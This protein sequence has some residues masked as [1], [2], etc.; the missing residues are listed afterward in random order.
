M[1]RGAVHH[2]AV[3]RRRDR[4]VALEPPRREPEQVPA[5]SQ[6]GRSYNRPSSSGQPPIGPLRRSRRWW[7]LR[8]RRSPARRRTVRP[9]RLTWTSDVKIARAAVPRAAGARAART[10]TVTSSH[11]DLDY[12]GFGWAR[13]ER[14]W[15]LD[16][17]RRRGSR[18]TTRSCSRSTPPTTREA[19]ADDIELEFE[20]PRP[21]SG[22][23]AGCRRSSSA[24]CRGCRRRRRSCSRCATRTARRRVPAA[25]ATALVHVALG[26]VDALARP[27]TTAASTC[28]R[29]PPSWRRVPVS[30]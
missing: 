6:S 15:W 11:P 10:S 21:A 12:A 4:A 18:S 1:Y 19:L 8:P 23:R 29:Q 13:V 14:V 27:P 22:Q 17:R 5:G 24:G 16:R 28:G 9:Q 20:L 26:D 2:V 3:A 7:P 25:A 30:A